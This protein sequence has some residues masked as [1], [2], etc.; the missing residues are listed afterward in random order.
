MDGRKKRKAEITGKD[1]A[2]KKYKV[3]CSTYASLSICVLS[4]AC[5]LTDIDNHQGLKQWRVPRK[6]PNVLASVKPGIEPGDAGIWATCDMH[7]EGRCIAELRELFGE[8]RT[9]F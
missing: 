1:V 4:C 7:Q 2:N 6:D 5:N 8:V 9:I 3:C